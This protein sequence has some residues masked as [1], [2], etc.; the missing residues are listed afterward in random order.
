MNSVCTARDV[1]SQSQSASPRPRGRAVRRA[2]VGWTVGRELVLTGEMVEHKKRMRFGMAAPAVHSFQIR[3]FP[4]PHSECML[5]S[6]R[7]ACI[8]FAL[9]AQA[10]SRSCGD[11]SLQHNFA[12]T[13][14]P[15]LDHWHDGPP[16][17]ASPAPSPLAI[18]NCLLGRHLGRYPYSL[19]SCAF[20]TPEAHRPA[21][22]IRALCTDQITR[23]SGS[24]SYP[25][26]GIN[27]YI[28]PPFPAPPV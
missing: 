12:R 17:Q 18:R 1:D 11:L 22:P 15:P 2:V 19:F 14:T 13:I 27:R 5:H 28:L 6:G 8:L 23:R 25:S 4:I 3:Q 20:L 24:N 21:F 26:A 10:E 16:P 9:I 7:V